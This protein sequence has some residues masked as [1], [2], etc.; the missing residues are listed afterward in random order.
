MNGYLSAWK[1]L[2][3]AVGL[4]VVARPALAEDMKIEATL[5]W[6][7]NEEKSPDP[8]L[9]PVDAKLT[10]ELRKIF[11]WKNYFE[12]SRTNGVV[13]NR[14]SKAFRVSNKCVVEITELEGPKVEV[15]LIGEGKPVN[16]TTKALK[17]GDYFTLGGDSKNGS[18]WF[19]IISQLDEKAT[20]AVAPQQAKDGTN[21]AAAKPDAPGTNT[22]AK[23][24]TNKPTAKSDLPGAGTNTASK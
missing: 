6:A 15:K 2:L 11:A 4:V 3:V 10:E 5:V 9:K 13:P 24:G 16:K 18:A 8:K 20:S 12:V 17:R 14:G 22:A 21:K 1:W 19:V 7:T 23:N